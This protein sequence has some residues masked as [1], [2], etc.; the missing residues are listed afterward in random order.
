MTPPCL[1]HLGLKRLWRL[2]SQSDRFRALEGDEDDD[3]QDEDDEDADEDDSE[4]EE[5]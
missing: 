4:E 3:E 5:E 2:A 1:T